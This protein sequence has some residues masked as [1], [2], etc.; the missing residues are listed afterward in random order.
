MSLIKHI[1]NSEGKHLAS[2]EANSNVVGVD[3]DGNKTDFQDRSNIVVEN[4][5]KHYFWPIKLEE[6]VIVKDV[7]KAPFEGKWL[8]AKEVSERKAKR[9]N[10]NKN[11]VQV[12][13]TKD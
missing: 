3:A 6:G 12:R 10:A 7:D 13:A 11:P 4:Q 5:I 2:F 8:P 9:A 1:F